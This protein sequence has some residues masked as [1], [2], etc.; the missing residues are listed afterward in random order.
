MNK[1][2][3]WLHIHKELDQI[4][5]FVEHLE[6][7]DNNRNFLS[8]IDDLY[9]VSPHVGESDEYNLKVMQN[10]KKISEDISENNEMILFLKN[11]ILPILP[12]RDPLKTAI[13]KLKIEEKCILKKSKFPKTLINSNADSISIFPDSA[14]DHYIFSDMKITQSKIPDVLIV[15][16]RNIPQSIKPKIQLF[17]VNENHLSW[18]KIA[19]DC[20]IDNEILKVLQ[21]DPS[22]FN[23][24][25]SKITENLKNTQSEYIL[26]RIPLYYN[27]IVE[28]IIDRMGFP[29]AASFKLK[30]ELLTDYYIVI[31]NL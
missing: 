18:N 22:L 28:L 8:S 17:L 20:K 6:N 31:W 5:W 1:S 25:I 7:N 3:K 21:N 9:T 27:S 11:S 24:T 30:S 15:F 29:P 2:H 26:K 10:F 14:Q 12:P 13:E 4:R 16:N 19:P 23:S